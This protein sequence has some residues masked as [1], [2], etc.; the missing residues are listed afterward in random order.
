MTETIF[1]L[2]GMGPYFIQNLL[3]GRLVYVVMAWLARS[4]SP[5]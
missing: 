2:D 5:R 4:R 1:Q 3:L